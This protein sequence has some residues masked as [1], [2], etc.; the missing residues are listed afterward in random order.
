MTDDK[1][2]INISMPRELKERMEK[3]AKELG[4]NMQSFVV[5]AINEYMKQDSVVEM[6]D[7]FKKMQGQK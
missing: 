4:L 7:I 3:R 6:A 5:V 2:R 1:V